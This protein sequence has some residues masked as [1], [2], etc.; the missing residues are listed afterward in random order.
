MSPTVQQGIVIS[1]PVPSTPVH[2]SP[3]PDF[4][5]P[6]VRGPHLGDSLDRANESRAWYGQYNGAVYKSPA[7]FN[8]APGFAMHHHPL[9]H[10]ERF[11]DLSSPYARQH[12]ADDSVFFSSSPRA[13]S[14]P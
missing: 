6:M 4:V 1:G 12:Q 13:R 2:G 7:N 14:S 3:L 8:A 5:M 9:S 10:F 11:A